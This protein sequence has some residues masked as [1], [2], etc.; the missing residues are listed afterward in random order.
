[1]LSILSLMTS[2]IKKD[3]STFLCLVINNEML[4]GKS[5]LEITMNNML[6]GK[7]F[8]EIM[9]DMFEGKSLF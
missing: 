7:S 9:S 2:R 8:L 6:E 3:K 1:M 5:F 4:E